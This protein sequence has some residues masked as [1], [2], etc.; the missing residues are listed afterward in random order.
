MWIDPTEDPRTQ[1]NP[2]G[3]KETLREY[4]SNYRLTLQMKCEGLDA[5][6]L[7]R[8]SVPPSSAQ[9]GAGPADRGRPLRP[10]GLGPVWTPITGPRCGCS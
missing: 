3:E 1:G 10:R 8:R 9:E 4:L 7:A 2:Q 5:E 6:Q